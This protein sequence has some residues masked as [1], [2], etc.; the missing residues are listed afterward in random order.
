M[1]GPFCGG[2]M[3]YST[4]TENRNITVS[5]NF[6]SNSTMPDNVHYLWLRFFDAKNDT[7]IKNISFFIN[8][9]KDDK[10]LMHQLF[11]TKT[12]LML[13]KFY[14]SHD[15]EKLIING[16]R[17]PTLGGMMSENDTLPITTSVF[18]E[19]G[20][21]HVHLQ[22]LA[23]VNTNE[24][25]DQNNPPTFDSWWVVDDKGNISK[26]EN[27]TTV[28]LNP[29]LAKKVN[30][31]TFD[32]PG[33]S[34]GPLGVSSNGSFSVIVTRHDDQRGSIYFLDNYG[35]VVWSHALG[36]FVK[37]LSV[38]PDDKFI[39]A[40][41]I[42]VLNN[43]GRDYGYNEWDANPVLYVFDDTSQ[44]IY[45]GELV[46]TWR[47][48][49]MSSDGSLVASSSGSGILYSDKSGKTLWGYDSKGNV[50]SVAVSPS[51][52]FVAGC[53]KGDILSFDKQGVLLWD[54]HKNDTSA[55]SGIAVTD[56]GYVL[57]GTALSNDIGDLDFF[58]KYGNLVWSHTDS[59]EN[60]VPVISSD[61]QYEIETVGNSL[62]GYGD[63]VSFNKLDYGSTVPEF[64][65]TVPV[66]LIGL[67]TSIAFYSVKFRK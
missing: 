28:P 29:D 5:L 56:L 18:A 39:E 30:L 55:C 35:T 61:R 66:M 50:T 65:L 7:L 34:P 11:Y 42:Q 1:G 54:Y 59:Y 48:T 33:E 17:E 31:W 15:A 14:P 22:A 9:T 45:Q 52:L 27:S 58:D 19:S 21:Y 40:R 62:R 43:G 67:V 38:S 47:M 64:P 63:T 37:S 4:P 26:Y 16:T 8:A 44:V 51:G 46:P 3:Q 41:T 10:V 13:M 12:G 60:I 20:T 49:S 57:T 24:L 6:Y 2:N 23:L 32:P 53:T 36:G 25:V